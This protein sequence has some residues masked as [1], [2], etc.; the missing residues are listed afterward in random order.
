MS[1][2]FN[3]KTFFDSVRGPLFQGSLTQQQVDGMNFKLAEWEQKYSDWDMRWL[4]YALATSK[5]E[6]AS[7]MWPVEEGGKG[8]GHPYGKVNPKTGWAYYGRGDVQLTWDYNYQNATTRLGLTGTKNDLYLHAD[9]ALDPQISADIMFSGMQEGWFRPPHMF[10][11]YFDA[12]TEDPYNAREIINGDKTIVPSWSNGVS[13][14]NLIK[15]YYKS[16][17]SALHASVVEVPKPV[18]PPLVVQRY[19]LTVQLTVPTNGPPVAVVTNIQE[20]SIDE[21]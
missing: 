21:V 3:R 12:D 14:G 16:F 15:G 19:V 18:E 10:T 7:Q 4:A 11:K 13:I 20:K 5:H 1:V 17:L 6:T 8:V 2:Q 9:R